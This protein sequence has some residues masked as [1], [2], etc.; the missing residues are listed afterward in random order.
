MTRLGLQAL[1][2]TRWTAA[3]VAADHHQLRA[4]HSSLLRGVVRYLSMSQQ[5][6]QWWQQELPQC[7]GAISCCAD[8]SFPCQG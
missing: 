4:H 5:Q 2:Q 8:D 3:G 1:V 7:L 6:Q